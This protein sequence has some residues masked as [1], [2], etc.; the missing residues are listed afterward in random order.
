MSFHSIRFRTASRRFH[1]Y[2]NVWKKARGNI[3]ALRTAKRETRYERELAL[4]EKLKLAGYFLIVWD[5]VQF[6]RRERHSRAGPRLGG[7]QRRLLLRSESPP[8]IPSAWNCCSSAS[9][10]K[11]AANGRTSISIC[12]AAIKRERVIQYVYERYGK[13]GAAMTANVITYRG[14]SA[15]REVGKVLGFDE[16]DSCDACPAWFE[17]GNGRT[18]TT[19]PSASSA[20]P[21]STCA[22]RASANFCELYLAVQD[23]PRHLGQH[24]GGMVICQGRLDS[25]VPLEPATMPGRVVVQWD[26]DDCAD[27]GIIKVDLLGLGMMA[28]I[29]DTLKLI[30]DALRRR[31][32][33]RASSARRPGGLCTRLQKADTVGMF[34]VESRAQMSCC[35][36]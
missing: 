17:P 15:A 33:S 26:K 27:M 1:F 28:V 5:I 16:A 36:A 32:R 6:C 34:Q 35:P 13:L 8:S 21:A 24:S 10:P 18:R 11:S 20:T 30:R 19:H 25:V 31:G 29:E 9:F 7:Q 22:I 4:I 2:A 14:R 12:P 3:T 23:L